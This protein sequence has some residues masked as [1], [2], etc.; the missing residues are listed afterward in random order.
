MEVG[1]AGIEAAAI[2]TEIAGI[3]SGVN[4]GVIHSASLAFKSTMFSQTLGSQLLSILST[5][6]GL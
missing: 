5:W 6:R 1:S 3:K 2:S 4:C